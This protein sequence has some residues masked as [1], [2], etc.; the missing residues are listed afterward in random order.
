VFELMTH[1]SE[2]IA[3]LSNGKVLVGGVGSGKSITALAYYKALDPLRPIYVLTTAKKRD[4]GDWFA[5]AMKLSLT[6]EL[7]VDSWNNIKKY[8]DIHD[9]F[10]ILDE[11]RI[12]GSGTWVDAF[13]KVAR[14]NQ[15]ILLSATP[16]DTWVDLVPIFVANGFF[17]NKTQFNNEHVRF[18][19]FVKY[20]KIDGYYDTW[21]L[22]KYR[23]RLYVEMDYLPPAKRVEHLIEVDFDIH[24]Q[25]LL[26]GAR[27]NFHENVPLKDA[28]EMMRYLRQ[29]ANLHDSRYD[30]IVELAADHPRLIIFYNFDY[31]LEK[32]RLLHTELDVAVAEWNGHNHQDPPDT[33][34]WIYLVQ[35]QAGAEAWN[36]TT[37]D[38]IVFYSL[39]YSYRQF[40]QAK[41][42]IDRQN[43]PFE[44]LHYYIFKSRA[45]IDQAI[46]KALRRKKNFQASRFAKKSW[47]REEF[48]VL[49][50]AA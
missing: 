38:T 14:Q 16:A 47:P 29:S 3:K 11:Q 20:P 27:W 2:A 30:K 40:E 46:W 26:Y 22:E 25:K 42:R 24:E 17:R 45:I 35:Y 39:P 7:I 9:A 32:L 19:R 23:D 50:Q 31:E 34:R 44:E 28:G 1:Q 48:T 37:T 13:Y 33:E 36:C 49:N 5:D 4:S 43:T 10:F 18:S 6:N 12:V 21:L 8:T 41:G 15:W